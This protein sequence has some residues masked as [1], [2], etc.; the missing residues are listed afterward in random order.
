MTLIRRIAA[1]LTLT[2]ALS[3]SAGVVAA[4]TDTISVRR[5]FVDMPSSILDI[6]NRS[7]RLDMLDYYDADSIW[8]APNSMEGRSV[9]RAVT[10]SFIDVQITNVSQLQVKTLPWK[11]GDVVAVSYTI[12][13]A[14]NADDSELRFFN[15]SMEMLPTSKFFPAPSLRDYVDIPKGSP[16]TMHDIEE[17]IPFPTVRYDLSADSPTIRAT[18]T[19]GEY[20]TREAL[21]KVKPYLRRERVYTWDGSRFRLQK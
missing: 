14:G 16:M 13:S 18:L 1:I 21:A 11:K 19:V 2:G 4:P 20:L 3:A 10:P 5:A 7:T 15:S 6:L 8:Q 9:L 12:S 17:L